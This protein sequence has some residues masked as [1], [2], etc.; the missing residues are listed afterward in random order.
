MDVERVLELLDQALELQEWSKV[1]EAIEMIRIEYDDPFVEYEND[2]DLS[3][4]DK[5]WG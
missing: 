1:E 2:Q 5:L 4:A 3:D